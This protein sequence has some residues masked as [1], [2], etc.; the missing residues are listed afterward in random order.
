MI[1]FVWLLPPVANGPVELP[2]IGINL[3]A[4]FA[5]RGLGV[6]GQGFR[7]VL[8]VHY[9]YYVENQSGFNVIPEFGLSARRSCPFF[10]TIS[11][12]QRLP[13]LACP[14]KSQIGHYNS[15]PMG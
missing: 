4:N 14:A 10:C 1:A 11:E 3:A 8:T 2:K 13:S 12:L 5:K 9:I 15:G 7:R 6:N